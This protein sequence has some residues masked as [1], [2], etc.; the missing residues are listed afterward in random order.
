MRRRFRVVWHAV[1]FEWPLKLLALVGATVIWF[2]VR[3][4]E[5]PLVVQ[6][7][8]LAVRPTNVPAGAEFLDASPS[9]VVVVLRGR[10]SGI[11]RAKRSMAAYVDL[12]GQRV[13]SH[14]LPV[15]LAG[16]PK[17]V[18][19]VDISQER[20]RVRL[21][22]SAEAERPVSVH[23]PGLPAD[24][25]ELGRAWADPPAVHVAG[26][27][28][29][30]E[31]VARAV[32]VLDVSGLSS[33]TTREVKV[34]PRD[35]SGLPVSGVRVEPGVVRVTVPVQRV[36]ARALPVWPDVTSPPAG[37]QVVHVTVRPATVLVT[38]PR[39]L[40][41]TA[42]AVSTT[43]VDISALRDTRSYAVRL[44]P[45]QGLTVVGATSAVVKVTVAVLSPDRPADTGGAVSQPD[46]VAPGHGGPQEEERVPLESSPPG[47]DQ[48]TPPQSGMSPDRD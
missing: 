34:Q 39:K 19:V 21:D 17:G 42:Q 36:T 32:A 25:C 15:Q 26:P 6:S 9:E 14:D 33:T 22:A 47:R 28:S 12:S 5:D 43:R 4:I 45:P 44:V 11:E 46:A 16:R 27:A 40:L 24:G 23:T 2:N 31:R 10:R 13:G 18:Q 41:A 7:L 35:G 37:Y 29:A 48:T 30:V 20:V 8:S 1:K 3:N 38:G